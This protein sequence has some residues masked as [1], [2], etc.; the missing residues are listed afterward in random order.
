[1]EAEF[2]HTQHHSTLTSP[3][4]KD[5]YKEYNSILLIKT[6]CFGGSLHH[7]CTTSVLLPKIMRFALLSIY[8][9]DE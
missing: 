9:T 6:D 2:P 7:F 8:Q 4:V 1:M 5:S 3:M